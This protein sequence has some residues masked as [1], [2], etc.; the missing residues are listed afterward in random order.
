MGAQVEACFGVIS[1]VQCSAGNF[2]S[3]FLVSGW[4]EPEPPHTWAIGPESVFDLRCPRVAGDRQIEFHVVPFVADPA[5]ATQQMNVFINGRQIG[6]E[7]LHGPAC[8]GFRLPHAVFGDAERLTVRLRC[9]D[10]TA[11][12]SVGNSTD[13]RP[14][15]FMFKEIR[16]RAVEPEVPF[17]RLLRH[18]AFTSRY[19]DSAADRAI[20]RGLTA[21]S[22][23]ELALQFESLGI[24]CLFGLFQRRCGVEPL[25]LLRFAGLHYPDLVDGIESAFNGIGN[26]DGL[27]CET[28]CPHTNGCC[29]ASDLA[30]N[31]TRT[32][33]PQKYLRIYCW[34][35][36]A[37]FWLFG[38][39]NC[40]IC[41]E[42]E[43]SSL[44]YSALRVCRP[45]MRCHSSLCYAAS[46]QMR[47]YLSAKR[48]GSQRVAYKP[49]RPACSV[50]LLTE[51]LPIETTMTR[52]R[53]IRGSATRPSPHG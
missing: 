28:A 49:W 22:L 2:P 8:L 33:H 21:L 42:R 9:P 7:N 15:T 37:G 24:N 48:Q 13:P 53:T 17:Q 45:P 31:S 12:A 6:C 36:K 39:R 40:M 51:F 41:Y 20:V 44:S 38:K 30:S 1:R 50:G 3:G 16:V 5:P 18:P 52:C 19:T 25:G 46:V 14:L 43:R 23:A 11:P 32:D 26:I 35:N 27:S 29:D 47:C 4:A 10:A 34:R